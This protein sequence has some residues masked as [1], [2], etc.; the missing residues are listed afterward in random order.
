MLSPGRVQATSIRVP[1]E[2]PTIQA[3]INAS[4]NGDAIIVSPGIYN[5]ALTISGKT[6]TLASEFYLTNDPARIDQTIIDG[7]GA[8]VITV[9]ATAGA[10]TQIIGFTI[11]NGDDGISTKA[12]TNLSMVLSNST[13]LELTESM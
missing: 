13:F 6:I 4:Q 7:G 5:E 11:Q 12:K 9:S 10:E 8:A 2:Y 3:A 1:Q